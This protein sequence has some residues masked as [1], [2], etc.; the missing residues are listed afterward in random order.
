M[1][2]KRLL[3]DGK[4]GDKGKCL[5]VGVRREEEKEEKEVWHLERNR[6]SRPKEK[7]YN[8]LEKIF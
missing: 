3:C 5:K 2:M 6:S 1:V 4:L 8:E 7:S